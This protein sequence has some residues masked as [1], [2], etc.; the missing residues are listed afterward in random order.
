MVHLPFSIAPEMA[1][2]YE[3]VV[4]SYIVKSLYH[5]SDDKCLFSF[6]QVTV[7]KK[8]GGVQHEEIIIE[9]YN[10]LSRSRKKV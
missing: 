5:N 3:F 10:A 1:K 4:W 7:F 8:E 6:I 9:S 2:N